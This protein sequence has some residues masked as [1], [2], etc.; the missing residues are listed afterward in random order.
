MKNLYP[1]KSYLVVKSPRGKLF[2]VE[3]EDIDNV[4]KNWTIYTNKEY[5]CFYNKKTKKLT[6]KF[7]GLKT[8]SSVED[9]KEEENRFDNEFEFLF[10]KLTNAI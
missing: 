6:I 10:G 7:I 3:E 5:N 1:N 8:L 9:F 4:P 2:K